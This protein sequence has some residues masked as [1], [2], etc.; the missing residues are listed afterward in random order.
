MAAA[1]VDAQGVGDQASVCVKAMRSLLGM[2]NRNPL[3]SM[4]I[5]T[6]LRMRK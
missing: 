6:K 5:N 4:M 3:R 2:R 1:R